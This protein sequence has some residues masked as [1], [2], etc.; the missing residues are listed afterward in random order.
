MI[1]IKRIST[2]TERYLHQRGKVPLSYTRL[3]PESGLSLNSSAQTNES[4]AA[5]KH[6]LNL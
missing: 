3:S 1:D 4:T 2:P 5:I 6:P